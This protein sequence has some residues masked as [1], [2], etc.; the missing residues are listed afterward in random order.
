MTISLILA[1]ISA[2]CSTA[3]V[4]GTTSAAGNTAFCWL[5]SRMAFSLRISSR[6]LA[7]WAAASSDVSLASRGLPR[8]SSAAAV[9]STMRCSA[10]LSSS[11]AS[12]AAGSVAFSA[13]GSTAAASAAV[14]PA[15]V[16][17][18]ELSPTGSALAGSTAEGSVTAC[19]VASPASGSAAAGSTVACSEAAGSSAGS[20]PVASCTPHWSTDGNGSGCTSSVLSAAPAPLCACATSAGAVAFSE[21]AAGAMTGSL[22]VESTIRESSAGTAAVA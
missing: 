3:R 21:P 7:S 20:S 6:I 10:A 16:G 22:C 14:G 13:A 9:G 5:V 12:T 4:A 19:A 15:A 17:S 1:S 8:S 2:F 18:M 11:V